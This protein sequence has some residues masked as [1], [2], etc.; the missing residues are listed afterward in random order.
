MSQVEVP[1]DSKA[2]T[3]MNNETLKEYLLPEIQIPYIPIVMKDHYIPIENDVIL[4]QN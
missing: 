2:V 4:T 1:R 3:R